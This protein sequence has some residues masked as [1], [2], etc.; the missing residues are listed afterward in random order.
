[1]ERA[2]VDFAVALTNLEGWDYGPEDFHRFRRMDPEGTLV[3][4]VGS[5]PVG[6]ATAT[7]YEKATWIGSIIVEP[8]E[9]GKGYGGALVERALEYGEAQGTDSSWLNAY[10]GMESFYADMGFRTRG[11]T[12]R[13]EGK[14]KGRLR[15]EPRLVHVSELD[16]LGAF[17][18]PYFGNDRAKVLTEFYHDYGD[19]FFVW[20]EEGIQGY[21]VGARY[22]GGMDVAPWVSHPE[23]PEVAEGLLL[24]LF[25]AFPD[26]QVAVAVPGENEAALGMLGNLG[27]RPA[28]ET[29]RMATGKGTGGIDPQGIF[30]LGGLEKG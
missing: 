7:A 1:M 24:H 13:Y 5:R 12:W 2:D 19:A 16:A 8:K 30:G 9:R 20:E 27:F 11:R 3:A 15:G 4:R 26:R 10:A 28:L 6:L 29:I 18:R 21:V 23:R 17:D 25:A 22:P 14:A